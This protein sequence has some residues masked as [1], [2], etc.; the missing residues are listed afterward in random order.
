MLAPFIVSGPSNWGAIELVK[1][2]GP[3]DSLY[4][5]AVTY[6]L[7]TQEGRLLKQGQFV[8]RLQIDS[9]SASTYNVR[10]YLDT[11]ADQRWDE[12]SWVPY[13]KPESLIIRRSI[14]IQPGFSST[15][16]FN[17]N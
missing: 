3:N 17:F 6:E 12:G 11:N 1:M 7:R 14:T 9:L 2:I 5:E 15:I 16:R 10:L 13:N 4:T 8:E